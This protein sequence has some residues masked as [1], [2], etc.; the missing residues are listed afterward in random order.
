MTYRRLDSR[1]ATLADH[2]RALRA[3]RAPA[4]TL[5]VTPGPDAIAA[6][7]ALWKAGHVAVPLHERLTPSE[8]D[9]ARQTVNSSLHIDNHSLHELGG[10][11]PREG[12]APAESLGVGHGG[13][14]SSLPPGV[15]ACI[16]TSGST[17][18]PRA[19]GFTRE[20]FAASAAAVARRLALGNPATAGASAC[21]RATS[22]A[23]RSSC[24]R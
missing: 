11:A 20:T 12:R 9:H 19:L 2:L 17:G 10:D 18:P 6:L 7:F 8:V 14:G 24:G 3:T 13:A 21:R 1:A 5:C 22:A 4:A 15:I 16:L 23:S